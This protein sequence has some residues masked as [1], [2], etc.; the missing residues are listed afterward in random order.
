MHVF[1]GLSTITTEALGMFIL[2][3]VAELLKMSFLL[4]RE[5]LLSICWTFPWGMSRTTVPTL[6]HIPAVA[7][8]LLTSALSVTWAIEALLLGHYINLS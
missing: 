5:A 6:G 8:L 4:A 1:P 7:T 2:R 3:A